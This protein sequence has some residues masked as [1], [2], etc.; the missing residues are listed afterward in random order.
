MTDAPETELP[1]AHT[2]LI[3]LFVIQ[4]FA[5]SGMFILWINAYPLVSHF[6][7]HA[8]P[9]DEAAGRHG[10]ILVSLCFSFYALAAAF[11]AFALPGCVARWGEGVV[12]GVALVFGAGGLTSLGLIDRPLYLAPAFA[13]IA[14]GWSALSNLPYAIAGGAVHWTRISGVLRIFS[15]SSVIPQVAVSLGLA[16]FGASLFGSATQSIML[17][18]GGSMGMGGLLALVFRGRI[19][20][21]SQ[22]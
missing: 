6:I 21:K 18:G 16:L 14:V 17:T 10:L 9:G 8:P 19:T 5:W 22:T 4:F 13:A 7:L 12:L 15:F 11:M 3:P 20:V 1:P 2:V